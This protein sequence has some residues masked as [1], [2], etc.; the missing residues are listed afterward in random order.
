M[1]EICLSVN[2][3]LNGIGIIIV[4]S[5]LGGSFTGGFIVMIYV[6]R[7]SSKT[8]AQ[9]ELER[10]DRF[11]EKHHPEVEIAEGEHVVDVA[12]RLIAQVPIPKT[13]SET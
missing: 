3:I 13:V 11:I 7:R 4:A 12:I 1:Q 9:R 2:E 8:K 10:L 6:R 5:S